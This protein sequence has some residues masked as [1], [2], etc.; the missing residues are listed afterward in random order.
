MGEEEKKAA[1]LEAVK[2][3]ENHM[4]LGIGTGSTV[5]P[6]IEALNDRIQKEKLQ[7]KAA[8]TSKAS[9]QA[10]DSSVEI[11]DSS[12]GQPLD[13]CVDGADRAS[14]DFYLIKGGGGALLKEKYVAMNA[15]KNITIVD[16]SKIATPLFG[17]PLPVEIV[18]F[19]HLA[20]INRI[21]ELGFS[22]TLRSAGSSPFVTEE[23]HFIFDIALTQ[24]IEDPRKTH[25]LL[26]ISEGVVET[27]LF[28]QTSDIIIVGKNDLSV[29]V[30]VK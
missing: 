14:S 9:E 21:E 10:L 29:D 27:G 1:A 17:H 30:W 20:T 7:L 16:E 19:G 23:G 28:L 8:V 12:L 25:N 2:Y 5:A 24:K 6:F 4:V 22:G 11:I 15:K 13:L 26:K 3:V 18:Q